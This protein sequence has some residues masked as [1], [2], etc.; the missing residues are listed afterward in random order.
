VE[1][2]ASL[3]A[4]EKRKKKSLA[5]CRNQNTVLRSSGERAPST[6]WLGGWVGFGA[7]LHDMEKRKFLTLTG[8]G[9]RPLGHPARS[10]SLY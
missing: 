4:V 2:R 1:T 10:Q 5:V 9:L 3:D 7:G 8:L 6:H